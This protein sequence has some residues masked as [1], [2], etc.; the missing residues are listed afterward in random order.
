MNFSLYSRVH[1][2]EVDGWSRVGADA[3]LSE[4]A[5]PKQPAVKGIEKMKKKGGGLNA[6]GLE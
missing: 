4:E 5:S 6:Q 3:L 2:S 1:I